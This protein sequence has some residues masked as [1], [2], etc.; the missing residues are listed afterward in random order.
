MLAGHQNYLGSLEINTTM[1]IYN[2]CETNIY[3]IST[4]LLK[5]NKNYDD[6]P[7]HQINLIGINVREALI[8]IIKKA[9][10]LL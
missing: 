4:I 2:T 3:Y 9:H 8:L 10:R 7:P 5:N 1:S 6:K